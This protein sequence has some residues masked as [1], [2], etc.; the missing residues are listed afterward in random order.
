M[1]T[2]ARA[3][4]VRVLVLVVAGITLQ[5]C[6]SEDTRL[7][8]KDPSPSSLAEFVV[9]NW[10]SQP[11]GMVGIPNGW[12]GKEW[13]NSKYDFRVEAAGLGR[14]LHLKSQ[15][16]G[17]AIISK[18]ARVDIQQYPRLEWQWN[19]AVL[20]MD[21]DARKGG[22]INDHSAQI[23]VTFARFPTKVRSRTIGYVWDTFAP[24]GTIIKSE[25]TVTITYIVVR[26]GAADHGKWITERRNVREDYRQIYGEEPYGSVDVV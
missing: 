5:A 10:T 24:T 14:V 20:S 9:E 23:Y 3:F 6:G 8:E 7:S 2:A 25:K 13:G 26:S 12:I 4:L 11:V 19:V 21:G 22:E 15:R 18:E 1:A 16:G 17:T